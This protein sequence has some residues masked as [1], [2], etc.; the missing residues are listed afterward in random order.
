VTGDD[1][2]DDID[3]KML[4]VITRADQPE[5]FSILIKLFD[6][7]CREGTFDSQ[8]PSKPWIEIEKLDLMPFFWKM[9]ARTFGYANNDTSN[10]TDFLLRVLVTDFANA[11]KS[12]PP[13]SISHFIMPNPAQAMNSS[14][15]L[16]QWRSNTHHFKNYNTISRFAGSRLKI[17][18]FLSSIDPVALDEVMTFEAVERRII[19]AIRDQLIANFE[20]GYLE[21]R[22]GIKRRLD[23][24]WATTSLEEDSSRNLY[25]TTYYAMLSAIDLFELRKKY[26]A[27]FPCLKAAR[28]SPKASGLTCCCVQQ[29]WN[30]LILRNV[31]NGICWLG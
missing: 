27:G 16:S 19:S 3:L 31:S 5:P 2:E 29:A 11:I 20:N 10:L 13:S 15:F 6:S 4:A 21:M 28:R 12:D 7:F 22:E 17:N 1:Q 8:E 23:G 25:R 18:E 24:Y 14:V 9:L 30:R 26:D